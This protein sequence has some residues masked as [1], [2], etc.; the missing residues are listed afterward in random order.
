MTRDQHVTDAFANFV[1]NYNIISIHPGILRGD[2]YL[3]RDIKDSI[4]L[5]K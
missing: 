5:G 3:I 4:T 1:R 2:N